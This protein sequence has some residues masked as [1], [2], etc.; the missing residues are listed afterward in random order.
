MFLSFIIKFKLKNLTP[1]IIIITVLIAACVINISLKIPAETLHIPEYA[2]LTIFLYRAFVVKYH[3]KKALTLA[4][5]TGSIAGIID[6]GVIQY[7]LPTR[8]STTA[9]TLLNIAGVIVGIFLILA[10]RLKVPA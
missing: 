8:F 10:Y 6:E 3:S 5:I 7:L 9:D 2:I 1:Y 4:I